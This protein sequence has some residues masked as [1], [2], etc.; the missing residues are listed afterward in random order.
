V[1]ENNAAARHLYEECGFAQALY[2]KPAGGA[3]F[4]TKSL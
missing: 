3:L 1:Q 4:Y 2:G